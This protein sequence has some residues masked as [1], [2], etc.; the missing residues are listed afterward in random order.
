MVVHSITMVNEHALAGG[1]T[2]DKT[3]A[4]PLIFPLEYSIQD[5]PAWTARA[6]VL[7]HISSVLH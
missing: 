3:Q 6:S 2:M 1:D 5:R 7:H 4:I